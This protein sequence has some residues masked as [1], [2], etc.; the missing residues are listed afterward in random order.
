MPFDLFK[1]ERLKKSNKITNPWKLLPTQT[2]LT[3]SASCEIGHPACWTLGMM[4]KCR[5]KVA[6]AVSGHTNE[7]FML[8]IY[9]S[10][11]VVCAQ[12]LAL[13]WCL[14]GHGL[15]GVVDFI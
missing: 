4:T 6:S 9:I 12:K 11:L 13:P 3:G 5:K 1:A 2:I 14:H 8:S 15:S 10:R 7:N